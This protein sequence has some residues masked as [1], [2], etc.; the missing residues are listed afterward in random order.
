M[1]WFTFN[2]IKYVEEEWNG[3]SAL[4]KYDPLHLLKELGSTMGFWEDGEHKPDEKMPIVQWWDSVG[5]GWISWIIG[6]L[7]ILVVA[8]VGLALLWYLIKSLI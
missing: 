1:S 5:V 6:G 2:P 4:G 7:A 8:V 3:H